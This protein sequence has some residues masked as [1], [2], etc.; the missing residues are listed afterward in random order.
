MAANP[1]IA[2]PVNV[3][4]P[5]SGTFILE[6]CEM[7]ASGIRN[8]DWIE[9]GLGAFALLA[10]GIAAVVDPL[11]SLIAAGLGWLMEH[12]EP[13]KGWLNDLTGDAGEVLGFAG[14]WDNISVEMQGVADEVMR[15]LGDLDE[16]AGEMIDA[17][18]RF[19]RDAAGH[20]AAAST[21]ASAMS[22]GMEL[23]STT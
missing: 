15:I 7:I 23:A 1:L 2:G 12:M 4:T 5:F 10:D 20:I 3:S 11:G 13:I 8:G 22:A 9:G 16:Q 17:Y 19:Q 18:R 14:T 6:D 21:L